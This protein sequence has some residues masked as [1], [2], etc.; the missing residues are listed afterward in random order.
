MRNLGSE[1]KPWKDDRKG[2]EKLMGGQT[3]K[4][5]GAV[6]WRRQ[7]R[8]IWS[9]GGADPS[10]GKKEQLPAE[11]KLSETLKKAERVGSIRNGGEGMERR[12]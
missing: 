5:K 1:G 12:K 9:I 4:K 7:E 2:Q 3:L 6:T 8:P 11:L 10:R